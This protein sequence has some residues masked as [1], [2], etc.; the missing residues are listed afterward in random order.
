VQRVEVGIAI[1]SQDDGLAVDDELLSIFQRSLNDPWEAFCPSWPPRLISRTRSPLRSTRTR[2]VAVV[3]DLG[4]PL[5]TGRNFGGGDRDAACAVDRPIESILRIWAESYT[6]GHELD[7]PDLDLGRGHCGCP[8]E[9]VAN[10]GLARS[11]GLDRGACPE[12][13]G[14]SRPG[15]SR[16]A[17][18]PAITHRLD[19]LLVAIELRPHVSAAMA[20]GSADEPRL[21]VGQPEIIGP[22]VA[23]DRKRMAAAIVGAVDQQPT[24]ALVAHVGERDFLRAR[25]VARLPFDVG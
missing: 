25:D 21:N 18:H 20:T 14:S 9:D 3:L 11:D 17:L 19:G 13:T 8:R 12:A 16:R 2:A 23:A 4:E 22:A 10:A 6:E 1:H 15:L 7:A 5:G 24:N